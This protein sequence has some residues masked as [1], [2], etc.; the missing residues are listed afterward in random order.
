VVNVESALAVSS[1]AFF[2]KI[3]EQI[4]T[5]RG[6]QPILENEVRKFGFGSPTNIDLPYEYAGTIPNKAL[7]KRMADIGAISKESGQASTW[8]T[9]FCFPLGK[10][11][12]QQRQFKRQPL[13]ARLV[14]VAM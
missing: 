9:K 7:K 3:G 10:G 12:S 6:Y 8:V 1:D 13:T 5:E 4:L 14:T 2:Y 11:C